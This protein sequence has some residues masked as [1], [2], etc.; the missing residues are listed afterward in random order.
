MLEFAFIDT[1]LERLIPVYENDRY[2]FAVSLL[3]FGIGLDVDDPEREGETTL[4]TFN[5]VLRVVTEM[6]ARPRVDIDLN[7]TI[8]G[9]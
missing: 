7:R 3:E 4:Y 9:V 1:V 2:L 5:D 8:H 6:T